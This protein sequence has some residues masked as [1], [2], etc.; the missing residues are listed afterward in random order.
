MIG[1]ACCAMAVLLWPA[2]APAAERL[3]ALRREGRVAGPAGRRVRLGGVPPRWLAPLAGSGCAIAAWPFAGGLVGLAAGLATACLVGRV[4]ASLVRR[5]G[6]AELA[7]AL[8]AVRLARAELAAGRPVDR[9]LV[10]AAEVVPRF[11]AD[12]FAAARAVL[13]GDVPS[14]SGPLAP[15]GAALVVAAR[16]GVPAGD[17]LARVAGDLGADAD[18]RRAVDAVLAGP[19]ASVG[20][21]AA[22]PLLGLGLGS[23]M[24]AR[25][26]SF[27]LESSAGRAL[28][29][30]GVML[31][32]LG[33]LWTARLAAGA[34][35]R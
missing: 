6:A 3:P 24:G 10:A 4:R 22:L 35:R 30:G 18:R 23:A 11:G 21:L 13:A 17:V 5:D 27:L 19:R 29:C 8:E 14:L 12:L 15:L 2:A 25:P 1:L 34:Q 7:A 28:L 31:D 33:V 20:L 9:C 16:T 32:V 26:V